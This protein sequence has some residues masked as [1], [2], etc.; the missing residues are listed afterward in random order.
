M[1]FE[2]KIYLSRAQNE[3]NLSLIIMKISDNK[4]MQVSTFGIKEDTYY[5]ATI[6]HAYYCIFYGAK[7]YLL[8][9]G[10]K[11]RAPEAQKNH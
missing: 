3:L 2:Y 4:E 11:T 7:A 9:K 10:I 1:D 5:N 6:S 8:L